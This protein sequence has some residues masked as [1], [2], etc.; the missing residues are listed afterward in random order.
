MSIQKFL[1]ENRD[2]RLDP[3]ALTLAAVKPI[4]DYVNGKDTELGTSNP[5]VRVMESAAAMCVSHVDEMYLNSKTMYV[6]LANTK[7]DLYNHISDSD[8]VG[9]FATPANTTMQLGL[10]KD[11]LIANAV[12]TEFNYRKVTIPRDT[13]ISVDDMNFILEYPIEIRIMNHGGIRVVYDSDYETPLATLTTNVVDSKVVNLRVDGGSN[14]SMAMLILDLKVKQL[15]RLTYYDTVTESMGFNKSYTITDKYHYARVW[16]SDGSDEWTELTTTHSNAVYDYSNPTAIVY[17]LDNSL[18]IEIPRIYLTEGLVQTQIRIDIYTT[19]GAIEYDLGRVPP[20]A[21][22]I[23]WDDL[24]RNEDPANAVIRNFSAKT[25]F[26]GEL[27]RG[28]QNDISFEE[29]RSKIVARQLGSMSQPIT[30]LQ[31]EKENEFEGFKIV[32]DVDSLTGRTYIATRETEVPD[33][34]TLKTS[35][36]TSIRQLKLSFNSL[37]NHYNASVNSGRLTIPSYSLFK[38]DD[39]KVTYIDQQEKDYLDSLDSESLVNSFTSGKYLFTPFHYVVDVSNTDVRLRAY[40]MDEPYMGSKYFTSEN[41]SIA[42]TLTTLRYGISKTD[43]GYDIIIVTACDDTIKDLDDDQ[44]HLEVS[45]PATTGSS[46]IAQLATYEGRDADDNF[47]FKVTID[48]EFDIDSNDLLKVSNFKLHDLTDKTLDVNLVSRMNLRYSINIEALS[49]YGYSDID[50][51][52]LNYLYSDDVVGLIEESV[53]VGLGAPLNDLWTK[54]RT[55][56]DSAVYATYQEDV[57]D[58]WLT[59]NITV[60]IVDG[61]AVVTVVNEAGTIKVDE[62]G[63]PILKHAAGEVILNELG[64]PTIEDLGDLVN[65]LDIC[66]MEG[67]FSIVTDSAVI[68]YTKSTISDMTSWINT[69]VSNLSKKLLELTE[70]KFYPVTNVGEVTALTENETTVVIP[71]AQEMVVKF[72]LDDRAYQ[73]K[74]TRLLLENTAKDV[75]V[76]NLKRRTISIQTIESDIKA[77]TGDDILTVEVSGLGG[78]KNYPILT[79]VNGQESLSIAKRPV[80]LN[81]G[82]ITVEDSVLFEWVKH[83]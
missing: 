30:N 57:F 61:S 17:V 32:K 20:S 28:G 40:N 1:D 78:D 41:Q 35:I 76:S 73:D 77:A 67:A 42:A 50:E 31:L 38:S 11:E 14:L 24:R 62:Q 79:L 75:I 58:T 43:A 18:R 54:C 36:G 70:L 52:L 13:I 48:T 56:K 81:D 68:D 6:S 37:S 4:E 64:E 7:E 55:Y 25:I 63:E 74:K 27:M 21:Y 12:D 19:K 8:L 10:A 23:K 69:S 83:L 60:D 46:Q 45:F 49:S 34:D 3:R 72:Y 82:N 16:M 29:L 15:K 44:L 51:R 5:V 2:L 33:D 80:L 65:R 26:S 9:A 71:A 22:S 59:D 53:E 66:L 39:G 47:I